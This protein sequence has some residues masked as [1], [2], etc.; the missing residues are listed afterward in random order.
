ML[1]VFSG[2]YDMVSSGQEK[3]EEDPEG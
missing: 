2:F 3:D 1:V